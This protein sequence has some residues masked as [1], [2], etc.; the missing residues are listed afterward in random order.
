M[1][2]QVQRAQNVANLFYVWMARD[3][4]G[5]WHGFRHEPI[6]IRKT[7]LD[8]NG[9]E[10][11]VGYWKE[12]E[13]GDIAPAITFTKGI[14]DDRPWPETLTKPVKRD[15]KNNKGNNNKGSF[16]KN[17]KPFNKEFNDKNQNYNNNGREKR[18]FT[19][20]PVRDYSKVPKALDENTANAIKNLFLDD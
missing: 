9:K 8:D 7:V 11:E 16:N 14:L 10:T 12:P 3:S 2:I 15:K 6:L 18:V 1:A 5:V 20:K 13:G 17:K 4:T 19:A